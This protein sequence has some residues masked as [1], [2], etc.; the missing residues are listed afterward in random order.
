[1]DFIP[2]IEEVQPDECKGM[3]FRCRINIYVSPTTGAYVETKRMFPLKRMSC[4]GCDTCHW[5]SDEMGDEISTINGTYGPDTLFVDDLVHGA[6]Y[7][8]KVTETSTDWETGIVD[9]YRTGF[10]K[11]D[12][13]NK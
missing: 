10:V 2:L 9:D 12:E 13:D 5:L 7:Q 3:F 11:I 8:Y 1:M 4:T 6:T